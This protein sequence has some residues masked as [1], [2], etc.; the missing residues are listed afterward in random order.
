MSY[1][2]NIRQ[3]VFNEINDFIGGKTLDNNPF[4]SFGR[5][6]VQLDCRIC[7]NTGATAETSHLLT[8]DFPAL[9]P[10]LQ[11]LYKIERI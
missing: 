9:H 5:L 1:I 6:S 10:F 8:V 2:L 4:V 11:F 7:V 3:K